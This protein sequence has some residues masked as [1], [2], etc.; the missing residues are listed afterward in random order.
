MM[1]V[2]AAQEQE[3]WA[4]LGLMRGVLSQRG[5]GQ[6]FCKPHWVNL[7]MGIIKRA[8]PLNPYSVQSKSPVQQV[9]AR[10]EASLNSSLGILKLGSLHLIS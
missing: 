2:V 1:N 8:S 10:I 4:T 9:C 6:A 3:M 5:S 7:L